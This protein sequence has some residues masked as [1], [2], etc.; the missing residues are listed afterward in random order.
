MA[1]EMVVVGCRLPNGLT[2]HHPKDRSISVTLSGPA[3]VLTDPRSSRFS[4][5]LT[6]VDAQLWNL[7]FE[8]YKTNPIVQSNSVFAG[9]NEAEAIAK[10]KELQKEK[11]GFEQMP[12]NAM[13]VEKDG[14]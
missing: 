5:G 8:A 12:Q 13:G 1:K 11:N 10:G 4:F 6:P 9:K 7:W 3:V 14:D 2:I